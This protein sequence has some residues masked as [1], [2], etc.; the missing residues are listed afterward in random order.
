M[1]NLSLQKKLWLCCG[2]LLVVLMLVG[3]IAYKTFLTTESLVGDVQFN[4]HKQNLTAAIELAIEKERVGGRDALL[5][6]DSK[7]LNEARADFDQQMATLKPLLSS[8]TS[9]K[10]Y[11]QI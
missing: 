9:H 4:V 10:L 7:Y 11:A 3:G 1:K 5:H 2:S 8:T 6:D